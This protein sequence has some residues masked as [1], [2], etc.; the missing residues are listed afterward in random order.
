MSLL[1]TVISKARDL[2]K[3]QLSK[4]FFW[5]ALQTAAKQGGSFLVFLIGTWILSKE[6]MGMYNYFMGIVVI[7][8]LF[9]DIGIS[10]ATSK[11]V[12]Q[13]S[14][15]DE[16][17]LKEIQFNAL[18]LVLLCATIIVSL[19]LYFGPKVLSEQFKN[20]V[21]FLPIIYFAP[22]A[23]VLDG[24]YRGKGFFKKLSV[25]TMGAVTVSIVL[26]IILV[27]RHGLLGL[28]FSQNA[29][30]FL[31]ATS[32]LIGSLNG[33]ENKFNGGILKEVVGY[34]ITFSLA[35][36]GYY[37]FSNI[38]VILI[39][40]FEYFRELAYYEL[41]NKAFIAPL[42]PFTI[43]GLVLAP[44]FTRD[45]ARGEFSK[46]MEGYKSYL[47][48]MFAA[49]ILFAVGSIFLVPLFVYVLA[50]D[51]F[52]PFLFTL[53]P[54]FIL[55]Y[56]QM[57]FSAPI[58]SGI[59]V[60]TGHARIMTYLNL[61]V[62]AIGAGLAYFFVSRGMIVESIYALVGVHTLGLILLNVFFYRTLKNIVSQN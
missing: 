2:P 5:G 15:T 47:K 13:Y 60:A 36:L 51:Y 21:Y 43:L 48:R 53:M 12:A 1:N 10:T 19:T 33:N 20:F 7:L 25:I 24:I 41:V 52:D 35:T 44:V 56:A 16:K 6:T 8:V 38:N 29:L 18:M 32:L 27:Q 3:K 49:G 58:N 9:V 40:R 11:Y 42:M 30:Y 4:D 50:R 28:A 17:K 57:A 34:S 37:L 14:Q 31:L 62:G 26:T 46:V 55:L 45:Y 61:V 39:G 22:I 54:P 59:I 23:S